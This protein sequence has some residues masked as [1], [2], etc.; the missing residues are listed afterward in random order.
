MLFQAPLI[1]LHMQPLNETT[2][3]CW[4]DDNPIMKIACHRSC[5]VSSYTS[6]LHVERH[7]KRNKLSELV[8]TEMPPTK[9]LRRS[10]VTPFN[11]VERCIFCGK[12]CAL[13]KDSKNPSRWRR[14]LLCRTSDRGFSTKTFKEV[15]LDV[16]KSRNDE[17]AWQVEVRLQGTISDLHAVDARYHDDCR[18]KFMAPRSIQAALDSSEQ[19]EIKDGALENMVLV[20]KSD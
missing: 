4:L 18:T 13:H 16:C 7:L 10:E 14:D 9:R 8:Y 3:L 15:I 17:W 5:G 19:S 6:A 20:M 1:K 11:F 2:M 12:M